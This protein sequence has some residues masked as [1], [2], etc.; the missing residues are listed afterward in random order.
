MTFCLE[1]VARVWMR[2][3]NTAGGPFWAGCLSKAEWRARRGLTQGSTWPCEQQL[4]GLCYAHWLQASFSPAAL[5]GSPAE[6]LSN[7]ARVA[8][9]VTQMV[10]NLPAM[11]ETQVWSLVWDNSHEKETATHSSILAWKTPWA[12]EAGGLQSMG[13]QRVGMTE[14]LMSRHVWVWGYQS[15]LLKLGGSL[16]ALSIQN[17]VLTLS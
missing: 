17:Y 16:L 3:E 9:L 6:L 11:Q 15:G 14:Q 4:E 5:P 10:K 13:S 8:S 1:F 2:V 12:E 7:R